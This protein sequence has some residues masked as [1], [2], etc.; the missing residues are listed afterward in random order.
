MRTVLPNDS[1]IL[2]FSSTKKNTIHEIDEPETNQNRGLFGSF[3][4]VAAAALQLFSVMVLYLEKEG[5]RIIKILLLLEGVNVPS[6]WAQLRHHGG[7]FG[8][9]KGEVRAS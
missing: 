7:W 4:A 5:G 2:T 1:S 6:A 8:L 9:Y 3:A